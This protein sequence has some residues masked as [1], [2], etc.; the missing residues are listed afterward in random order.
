VKTTVAF[1]CAALC[2]VGAIMLETLLLF[3]AGMLLIIYGLITGLEDM[4]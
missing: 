3:L 1:L 4:K 2:M